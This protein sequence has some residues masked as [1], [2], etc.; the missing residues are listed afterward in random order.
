[1]AGKP[2][3][4]EA[5][6]AL[7]VRIEELEKELSQ[8]LQQLAI[9]APGVVLNAIPPEMTEYS[10]DLPD[11]VVALGSLGMTQAMM[12]ARLGISRD[13]WDEWKDTFPALKAAATRART[14]ALAKMDELQQQA[15]HR[16]DNKFPHQA[17]NEF[18]KTL[19]NEGLSEGGAG[20][21]SKLV[22]VV[23]GLT[24]DKVSG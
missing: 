21:A 12:I 2:L 9:H 18:R 16:K 15:V 13:T 11:K 19:Q 4:R 6:A 1:M 10:A 8:A 5:N 20:D 3:Q 24:A 17:A 14:L 7:Q 22:R 23:N